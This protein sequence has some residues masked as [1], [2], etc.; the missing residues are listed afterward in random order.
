MKPLWLIA[1][2]FLCVLSVS[3]AQASRKNAIVALLDNATVVRGNAT[4]E[5]AFIVRAATLLSEL[6]D[7]VRGP[8]Q[9]ASVDDA[10]GALEDALRMYGMAMAFVV[11]NPPG[12]QWQATFRRVY[13]TG[14]N[15]FTVTA[16]DSLAVSPASYDVACKRSGRPP[17]A[18]DRI[19]CL[20]RCRVVC[21]AAGKPQ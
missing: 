10:A 17:L 8:V 21:Q 12:S 2:A 19:D 15:E 18:A 9:L 1:A 6:P 7:S 3:Q 11:S 14:G 13:S 5:H 4:A 16:G 20:S